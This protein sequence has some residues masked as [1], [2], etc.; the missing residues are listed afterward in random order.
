M[1]L[2]VVAVAE[3]LVY[4]FVAN[5]VAVEYTTILATI[6]A[7]SKSSKDDAVVASLVERVA[8][9]ATATTALPL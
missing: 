5:V 8:V 4:P 9:I 7:S 6:A 2:K 3:M 1:Q